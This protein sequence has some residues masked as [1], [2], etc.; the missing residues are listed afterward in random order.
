MEN[1]P[2]PLRLSQRELANFNQFWESLEPES[3]QVLEDLLESARQHRMA[4]DH[5]RHPL[6]YHAY[7]LT[8]LIEEHKE[9]QRLQNEL[10][11]LEG[12]PGSWLSQSRKSCEECEEIGVRAGCV[13]AR[14]YPKPHS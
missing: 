10:E 13:A 6:P 11:A 3:R 5:S 4:V 9:I 12:F 7:L 8:L 1:R 2:L 14:S